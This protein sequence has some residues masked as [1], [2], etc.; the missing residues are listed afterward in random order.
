M[1]ILRLDTT[2]V[3]GLGKETEEF[4]EKYEEFEDKLWRNTS[5]HSMIPSFTMN[6]SINK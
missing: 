2:F 4:E 5:T 1:P 3:D 6:E